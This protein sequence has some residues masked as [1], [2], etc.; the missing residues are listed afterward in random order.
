VNIYFCRGLSGNNQRRST[1]QIY[2]ER[3]RPYYEKEYSRRLEK[4]PPEE[5]AHRPG[6]WGGHPLAWSPP[7]PGGQSDATSWIMPLPP[8][9]IIIIIY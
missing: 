6:R 4:I 9:R 3:N 1:C 8:L 5:R 7:H 2:I